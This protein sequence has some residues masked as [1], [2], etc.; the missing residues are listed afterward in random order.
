MTKPVRQSLSEYARAMAGGLL[1]S[2]PLLYTMELWQTGATMAPGP[3]LGYMGATFLLL[4]GYNAYAGLRRS[5]TLLD[6]MAE[7]VEEMG[8]GMVVA[9]LALWLMG[10]INASSGIREAVGI[11]VIASMMVAIGVSVGKAQLGSRQGQQD[12]GSRREEDTPRFLGQFVLS[13]CGAVFVASNVAPTQEIVIVGTQAAPGQ[14][15]L[16]MLLSILI[17]GGVLYWADFHGHQRW[18][19]QAS[20]PDDAAAGIVI[21]YTAALLVSALMLWF[22]GRLTQLPLHRAIAEV[23]VLGL[24]ASLGS[25]AG[26]LLLQV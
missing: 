22:F 17:G 9:A 4:L 1:F 12:Q 21:M 20:G 14:I 23:V 2:I 5:H 8:L 11:V 6:V 24:P 10:R 13:L 18:V 25:S 19:R 15:L 7:S 26:R 3:L 16:I